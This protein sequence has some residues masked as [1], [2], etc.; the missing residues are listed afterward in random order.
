ML[1]KTFP[2]IVGAIL[3][4]SISVIN[5]EEDV[6]D[7]DNDDDNDDNNDVFPTN[8]HRKISISMR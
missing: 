8:D 5:G 3:P 6:D 4:F 2:R 1:A 7:D